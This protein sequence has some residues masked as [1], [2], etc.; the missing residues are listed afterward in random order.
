[1]RAHCRREARPDVLSPLGC[2]Y[3]LVM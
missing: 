3:F 1:M 2:V